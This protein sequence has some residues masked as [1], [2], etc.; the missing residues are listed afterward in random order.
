MAKLLWEPNSLGD[1]QHTTHAECALQPS[2]PKHD[3]L[4]R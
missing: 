4:A 1:C 3:H 2:T